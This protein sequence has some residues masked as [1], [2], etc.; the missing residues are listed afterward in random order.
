[1]KTRRTFTDDEKRKIWKMK[2]DGWIQADIARHFNVRQQKISALLT[3]RNSLPIWFEFNNDKPHWRKRRY[4]WTRAD[5]HNMCALRK[6]GLEMKDVVRRYLPDNID[7]EE[8]YAKVYEKIRRSIYGIW[9]FRTYRFWTREYF[10]VDCAKYEERLKK[11]GTFVSPYLEDHELA[12]IRARIASGQPDHEIA[13]VYGRS[14]QVIR[15]IRLG[16]TYKDT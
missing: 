5:V 16:L 1:M 11:K 3:G 12:D 8:I 10:P 6:A 9:S 7:D 4:M 14:E 13:A 2:L 15:N